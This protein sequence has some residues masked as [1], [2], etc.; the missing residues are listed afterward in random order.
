MH[1]TIDWLGCARATSL[2]GPSPPQKHRSRPRCVKRASHPQATRFS[3][4]SKPG[5]V[6]P[7]HPFDAQRHHTTT[8]L[9]SCPG[10]THRISFQNSKLA[11]NS[12]LFQGCSSSETIYIHSLTSHVAAESF[13]EFSV[14]SP[15]GIRRAV[16][17]GESRRGLIGDRLPKA[18][19]SWPT[20]GPHSATPNQPAIRVCQPHARRHPGLQCPITRGASP[21]Q[22]IPPT[23]ETP[24]FDDPR[25]HP[26]FGAR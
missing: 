25:T 16:G 23:P 18:R 8:K 5:F 20:R 10:Q 24:V 6:R 19:R 4:R 21:V 15:A 3:Q 17:R 1:P 22:P 9:K 2:A 12:G 11:I 14:N 13:C 7:G 26:C